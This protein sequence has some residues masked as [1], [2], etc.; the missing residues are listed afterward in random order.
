MKAQDLKA[1]CTVKIGGH[2]VCGTSHAVVLPDNA[3]EQEEHAAREFATH[4]RKLTG[5]RLPLRRES[6]KGDR[7]P[8]FVGRT[9]A[10]SRIEPETIW[11]ELGTEGTL[12]R[13][14]GTAL[15]LAGGRRGTLYACYSFLEDVLGVRW[16]ARDCTLF[17]QGRKFNVKSFRKVYVPPLEYRE[18]FAF[19]GFDPDWSV[20]NKMNG[21][22]SR[23]DAPRGGGTVY[24]GFV[25]TFY[26]LVPPERY[27]KTNPEYFSMIDGERRSEHGQLCLT[28]ED[29][30][31]VV[32]EEVRRRLKA[33]P[34]AAIVSIS[35]NDSGG[36]DGGACQCG[37]CRAVDEAEGSP[38]GALLRFVNAVAERLEPEFPTVAFDTLAYRYTRKPPRITR[39]RP[40]V[41]VRLCSIE[42]S[43]A[44][45]M[46]EGPQNKT[47]RDDVIGWSHICNRLYVWDYV[48]N[49]HHY[50]LPHPNFRVLQPNI[51]FLVQHGVRGIF[52]QG[53]FQSPGGE[54]QELRTWLLA[55]L[56]WNPDADFNSLMPTFLNGYYGPAAAA[57]ARYIDL[58]HDAVEKTN[59]YLGCYSPADAPFLTDAVRAEADRLFNEAEEAVS[60]TPALL[61]RVRKARLPLQ[62]LRIVRGL[63]DFQETEDALLPVDGGLGKQIEIFGRAA[64]AA[65]VTHVREGRP[66]L[67]SKLESWQRMA[68]GRSIIR[69]SNGQLRVAVL[70]SLGGRILSLVDSATGREWLTP[71]QRDGTT[72][73]NGGY[74]EYSETGY[75]SPGWHE[76]YKANRISDNTV[77]LE[78]DLENGLRIKRRI[79]LDL[80]KPLVRIISTLL[81]I[82]GEARPACLRVHPAWV[83]E[84]WNK[85]SLRL[86]TAS[87]E[88]ETQSLTHSNDIG[89][90]S[91]S[92]EGS[93]L[94]VGAWAIMYEASDAALVNRFAPAQV[95]LCLL[96]W[97]DHPSPRVHLELWS[98][99]VVLEPGAALELAHEYEITES[100]LPRGVSR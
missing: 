41:I 11:E 55:K 17:S 18:P 54:F 29:L 34:E 52:E 89:N 74:E 36:G 1:F 35:Q 26:R 80:V 31:E 4:L 7:I 33:N 61:K 13:C 84:D 60:E 43:F 70:P 91:R 94:P 12:T 20:R 57:I 75:R 10:I 8:I 86:R 78:A 49:F 98:P 47:F 59:T 72:P 28:N 92:F 99:S 58:M 6:Q 53:G 87:G 85:M 44:Q 46:E 24:E 30:L 69:L 73:D 25:H 23:L 88:W 38:S 15:Y 5:E 21:S 40:S 83:A 96:N 37:R 39:P 2:Q 65:G 95:K 82:S 62:Y 50:I 19:C 66:D 81:N 51:R 3:T 90:H 42:C 22:A 93:V 100:C 97:G 67:D 32:I 77:E 14:S 16:L 68:T 76:N 64:R 56:L 79:E 27:F 45:T 63:S 9:E 71:V 48:T